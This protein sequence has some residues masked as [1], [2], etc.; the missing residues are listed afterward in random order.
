MKTCFG[1]FM[2]RVWPLTSTVIAVVSSSLLTAIFIMKCMQYEDEATFSYIFVDGDIR[3]IFLALTA[4]A[5]CMAVAVLVVLVVLIVN[6]AVY[7]EEG[8]PHFRQKKVKLAVPEFLISQSNACADNDG[9]FEPSQS[10]TPSPSTP[11]LL[12]VGDPE[13]SSIKGEDTCPI[14]E[15]P[16]PLVKPM[17]NRLGINMA[18]VGVASKNQLFHGTYGLYLPLY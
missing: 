18:Q 12:I 11:K 15:L 1:K 14:S 8:R 3:S 6:E 13:T 7:C 2:R 9:G 16:S 17:G 10:G 5:V 4:L